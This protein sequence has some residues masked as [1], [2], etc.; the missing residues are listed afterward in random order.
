MILATPFAVAFGSNRGV[1]ESFLKTA[2]G[3]LY[4]APG[5]R[6]L[7]MSPLY[8]T[9]PVGMENGA[10]FLNA[11]GLG[12]TMLAA[13]ELLSLFQRLEREA[14]RGKE[15]RRVGPPWE[16][17][18]LDLDLL[19]HGRTIRHEPRLTLPHP[20]LADRRFV[21]EPLRQ[22]CPSWTHPETGLTVDEMI[23]GLP[24]T[25]WVRLE[26]ENWL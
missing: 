2:A 16:D 25:P 15:S 1:C 8:R 7:R 23:A 4:S 10:E 14:G 6:R 17:R 22:V 11:V 24:E 3:N 26:K 19:F 12:E 5:C 21:L 9:Q 13:V 20:R 18:E